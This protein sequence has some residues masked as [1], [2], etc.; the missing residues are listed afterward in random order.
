MYGPVRTVVWQGSAGDRRP[1]ADQVGLWEASPDFIER[2]LWMVSVLP[3]RRKPT[4]G[5]TFNPRVGVCQSGRIERQADF[6]GLGSK[7]NS[8]G[9]LGT[10]LST[11]ESIVPLKS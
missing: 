5:R 9:M 2:R 11:L 10:S 4:R 6:D 7:E 1:Y 3:G 8:P